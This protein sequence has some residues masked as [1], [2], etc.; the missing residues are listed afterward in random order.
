MSSPRLDPS[1]WSPTTTTSA[2]VFSPC[3]SGERS[4][5]VCRGVRANPD[6]SHTVTVE[7]SSPSTYA[8]AP[9]STRCLGPEPAGI[10][11]RVT[12]VSRPS[13]NR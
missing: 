2:A 7:E 4:E 12:S 8:A 5:T 10:A 13:S 1:T 11:D 3:A 9:S 6:T